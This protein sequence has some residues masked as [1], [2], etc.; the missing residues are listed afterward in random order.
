MI[1]DGNY[2]TVNICGVW[3]KSRNG[4]WYTA[5]LNIQSY[6]SKYQILKTC[7]SIA[8]SGS[9]GPARCPS[10]LFPCPILSHPLATLELRLG[11]C[12]SGMV[13]PQRMDWGWMAVGPENGIR[14]VWINN[15]GDWIPGWPRKS[16]QAPGR[17]VP[18]TLQTPQLVGREVAKRSPEE[19]WV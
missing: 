10:A 19:D 16:A 4:A 1:Y 9:R 14:T 5:F 2:E 6:K 3:G 15:Y 13:L 11:S 8:P 18:L 7:S 12:T 17:H